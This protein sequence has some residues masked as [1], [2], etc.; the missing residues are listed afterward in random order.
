MTD[1]RDLIAARAA[2][3][4]EGIGSVLIRRPSSRNLHVL[5][6]GVTHVDP[7]VSLF[8]QDGWG[9]SR[10]CEVPHAGRS[11]R[12]RWRVASREA[13]AFLEEIEPHLV[14]SWNRQRA[15]V[16]I[17]FQQERSH[18]HD[19]CRSLEYA[20]TA[21]EHWTVMRELNA[22]RRNSPTAVSA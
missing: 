18:Q 19:E 16:G 6:V 22:L 15:H 3:L 13:S 12:W 2:G 20:A 10:D 4:F 14:T 9:G 1:D 17:A 8:F 7:T 5:I 21:D 11:P